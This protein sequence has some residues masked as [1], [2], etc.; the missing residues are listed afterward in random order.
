MV[1]KFLFFETV[2]KKDVLDLIKKLPGNKA[3]VS[4]SNPVSVFLESVPAYYE[5]LTDIFSNCKRSGTF[6][7][8]LLKNELLQVFKKGD[9]TSK[10]FYCPVN[11][12]SNFSGLFDIFAN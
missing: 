12:L 3:T 2:S 5:K 10:T 4:N 11:T 1:T 7:E 8:I 9:P 6:L